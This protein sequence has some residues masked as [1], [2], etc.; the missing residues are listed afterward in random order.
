MGAA[1]TGAGD[2]HQTEDAT[3]WHLV[4][5]EFYACIFQRSQEA[6][7]S[8]LVPVRCRIQLQLYEF[9]LK[10]THFLLHEK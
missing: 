5:S 4:N 6:S 7:M 10:K 2:P 8:A 9:G 1:F 3:L